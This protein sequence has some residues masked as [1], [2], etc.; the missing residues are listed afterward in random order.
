MDSTFGCGKSLTTFARL[1]WALVLVAGALSA[2]PPKLPATAAQV[3]PAFQGPARMDHPNTATAPPLPQPAP[4]QPPSG[5]QLYLHRGTLDLRES[6]QLAP[7]PS[8]AAVAPGPYAIIQLLGPVTPADRQA[9]ERTGVELL[10]YLPDYA[11]LVRGTGV[12]RAAAARLPQVYGHTLFTLGDKLAPA[13]LRAIARGDTGIWE[14]QIIG[15]QGEKR[16]LARDLGRMGLRP[17]VAANPGLLLQIAKLES[18]RWIEPRGHPRILN[19][20]ARNIVNVGPVW[21]THQLF[22]AGQIIAVADSGL[23]T[24]DLDTLSPDFAGRIVATQVISAGGHWDDNH[25][26]G[27]HV[28]GSIAGAG[29]QSGANVAQ[30]DYADSFAGVAPEAGLVIQ[31]FEAEADGTVVG[32]PADFYPLFEQA[33]A[34]GARLHSNSWGDP[35]G[36]VSDAEAHYGGYP[37]GSQR[38]DE[39]VWDHPDLAIFFA[40]GNS[41]LDGEPSPPFGFCLNGDGVV[42]PDSLLAPGTAKNV[43]TVGATESDRSTGGQGGTPWLLVNLCFVTDPIATDPLSNNPNG[44]AAFSSRGPVDDGRTKPDIVAPGTNI[45]SNRS[46]IPGANELWPTHETYPDDY[47]YSSGT[48]MA[49]PLVAGMGAL[50]REWLMSQGH[51]NPSGAAIKAVLLNTTTDIA[52]GQY[53]TGDKQEIPFERPNGVAGWGRADLGFIDAPMPYSLWLDDHA[54]GLTT[55]QVITYTHTPTHPLEVLTDTLPLRVMLTWTD[56]PASLSASKQL[57]NDLDLQVIGPGG[58]IYYGNV[59]TDG[60]RLNNVEG[61]VIQDPPLGRYEVSVQAFNVPTASQPY[62]LAVGGPLAARSSMSATKTADVSMAEVGQTITY[63]YR[64][65]NNNPV[66]LTGITGNDDKLGPVTFDPD[67]LAAG[68]SVVGTLTYTVQPGDLP[69]PLVNVVVVSGT[70][71]VGPPIAVSATAT[72]MMTGINTPPMAVA[73]HFTVQEGSSN[74]RLNVLANDHDDDGDDLTVVAVGTP[75]QGGVAING[76]TAVTYTP[77]IDFSGIEVFIYTVSDGMG[78][79]DTATVT[80]TVSNVNEAPVA[81]DDVYLTIL[82]APLTVHA[83]GVLDN[84]S[85]GDGD[86]L[87][88]MMIS[89]VASGTLVTSPW[90]SGTLLLGSNGGFVYTPTMGF[91]GVVTFTYHAHDGTTSSNIATVEITVSAQVIFLPITMRNHQ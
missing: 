11:Y 65:K 32:L 8:L 3:A 79:Y 34:Q 72:V 18:V 69:G 35:T 28:A 33:Y 62:A 41:G 14:V 16:A 46:H 78:G 59:I 2:L 57:V 66:T 64:V 61:I 4:Q 52:P 60:D 83:P 29:V 55:G 73:D 82:D 6:R 67:S 80:V 12:E 74:N 15:W 70:P 25:G 23:D 71:P 42:D 31:A 5:P 88:A 48:S 44:M 21:Q 22:G 86:P 49:T 40:A 30:R 7:V 56:P 84:D 38:T 43:I 68:Q 19:N 45:V 10:E 24:G 37:Y 63:T 76:G 81:V 39:F 13:L 54:A 89:P 91:G 9:L 85:D 26:H 90:I 53:G 77:E 51:V 20:Y 50:V 87:T 58:E 27:T 47:V 75:D 36:P 1:C 17:Y